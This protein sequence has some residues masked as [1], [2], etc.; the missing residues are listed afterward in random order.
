MILCTTVNVI[1]SCVD[2]PVHGWGDNFKLL[3]PLGLPSR[4]PQVTAVT[5]LTS[6]SFTVTWTILDTSYS[7][8]VILTNLR[9]GVINS[10]TVPENTNSY[11][12]TGLSENDNYN[13]SITAVGVCGM[14]TSD[15]ITV[16]GKIIHGYVIMYNIRIIQFF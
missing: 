11:T 15:P 10:S 6:R 9:T 5:P 4:P 13:V 12:V 3:Y 2:T 7:C 1:T 16:Y 8:R 14:I